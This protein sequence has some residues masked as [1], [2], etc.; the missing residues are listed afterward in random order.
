M[1]SK[2]ADRVYERT[3]TTGTADLVLQGAVVGYQSCFSAMGASVPF[4]YVVSH[5]TLSEWE[6]GQSGGVTLVSGSYVLG[7]TTVIKSS[8]ANSLVNFSA[9]SKDVR[10][11][12]PAQIAALIEQATIGPATSSTDA[13]SVFSD[14][15]GRLLRSSSSVKITDGGVTASNGIAL[16][17]DAGNKVIL[18]I[19]GSSHATAPGQ[20]YLFAQGAA[21]LKMAGDAG[22]PVVEIGPSQTLGLYG[23]TP[24][25]RRAAAGQAAVATTSATNSSPYGFTTAAQADA[26]VTLVNELRAALV[27]LG[28]IKGSA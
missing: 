17:N 2:F 16:A 20:A 21:S 4:Y 6:I 10:I 25:A 7:R 22:S 11:C 26:L 3:A 1:A 28:A 18:Q 13:V 14:T 15:T 8:N 9:G 24:I 27:A 23:A 19:N 12:L 5:P